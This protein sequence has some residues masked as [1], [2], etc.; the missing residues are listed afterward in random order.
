MNTLSKY[1]IADVVS[2]IA[3][4]TGAPAAEVA[5]SSPFAA[6]LAKAVENIPDAKAEGKVAEGGKNLPDYPAADLEHDG[7]NKLKNS[8]NQIAPGEG[9][10][11]L[12]LA[13]ALFAPFMR[14]HEFSSPPEMVSQANMNVEGK[15]GGKELEISEALNALKNSS[16]IQIRSQNIL[17]K[18]D[19]GSPGSLRASE[20]DISEAAVRITTLKQKRPVILGPGN[21]MSGKLQGE[22]LANHFENLSVRNGEHS[23]DIPG[24]IGVG[25]KPESTSTN[26]KLSNVGIES[27][28]L[29]KTNIETQHEKPGTSGKNTDSRSEVKINSRTYVESSGAEKNE[30]ALS[31]NSKLR[32]VDMADVRTNGRVKAAPDTENSEIYKNLGDHTGHSPTGIAQLDDSAE[33]V[34]DSAKNVVRGKSDKLNVPPV[35]ANPNII[36]DNQGLPTQAKPVKTEGLMRDVIETA[37]PRV[38]IKDS[39]VADNKL[40]TQDL[41]KLAENLAGKQRQAGA[42]KDSGRSIPSDFAID[43]NSRKPDPITGKSGI[44]NAGTQDETE[45]NSLQINL[46]NSNEMLM[47]NDKGAIKV[48]TNREASPVH[49]LTLSDV[50]SNIINSGKS[51]NIEP[52][53]REI[54]IGSQIEKAATSNR[55]ESLPKTVSVSNFNSDIQ[56][57]IVGQLTNSAKG[58]SKFTVALFPENFG[59]ISIEISYSEAAGLKINM[60]GDNPEA[61]KILE[62]N[63]PS[64][65]ENLQNEKLS[66]LIVNLNSSKDSHNS[67]NKNGHADSGSFSESLRSDKIASESEDSDVSERDRDLDSDSNLDT[68]V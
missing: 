54:L 63:L 35:S 43:V 17:A 44:T 18:E 23:A 33:N 29:D 32:Q 64:L 16:Q 6:L 7:K 46:K 3:G 5:E 48:G 50:D 2:H 11:N 28:P 42:S 68:Y 12:D 31:N 26:T 65:R 9:A 1:D 52:T 34:D 67:N 60:I 25:V 53:G 30:L 58:S 39:N 59:K 19:A 55:S 57:T 21:I 62:Q 47:N 4:N 8:L 13:R 38:S 10:P 40:S 22:A 20:E 27:A 56:E 41:R 49:D 15:E 36:A 37:L 24:L 61:T 14:N 51:D 45:K 66:E